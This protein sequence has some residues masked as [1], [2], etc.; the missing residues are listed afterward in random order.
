M[1]AKI[2]S[3]PK[4]AEDSTDGARKRNTTSS[5]PKP[6]TRIPEPDYTTEQLEAVKKIKKYVFFK[7]FLFINFLNYFF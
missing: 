1:L 5:S 3:T 4:G 7:L 6:E 2:S